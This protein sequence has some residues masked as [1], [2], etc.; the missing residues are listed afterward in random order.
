MHQILEEETGCS[1]GRLKALSL[2]EA[3]EEQ[4]TAAVLMLL[5]GPTAAGTKEL[6]LHGGCSSAAKQATE[7]LVQ[8]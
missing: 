4:D 8:R 3:A 7:G 5:Y 6:F 1:R 2:R